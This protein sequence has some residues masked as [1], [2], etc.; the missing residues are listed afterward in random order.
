MSHQHS[1]F[2]RRILSFRILLLVNVGVIVFLCLSLGREFVRQLDIKQNV[3]ALQE[4]VGV[5]SQ[6]HTELQDLYTSIQTISYVEREARL[7]LGLQK[8]GEQVVIVQDPV[9]LQALQEEVGVEETMAQ[10]ASG[11]VSHVSYSNPKKWWFYFF[12]PYRFD[13]LRQSL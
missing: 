8:P 11:E 12:D 9:A 6:R 1:S 10:I 2:F 13:T 5:L 7:K 3:A 4:E